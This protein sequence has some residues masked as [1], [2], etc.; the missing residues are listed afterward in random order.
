MTRS[1]LKSASML[2]AMYAMFPNTFPTYEKIED[3]PQM[4][5][6]K[7]AQKEIERNKAAG[8]KIFSYGEDKYV[9]ALNQENADRKARSKNWL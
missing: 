5:A 2:A 9:W 1:G 7:K 4:K 8:L 3:T 6:Y